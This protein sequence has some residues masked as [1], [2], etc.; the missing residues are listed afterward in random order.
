M[1]VDS[2]K[3]LA[4]DNKLYKE[5]VEKAELWYGRVIGLMQKASELPR[6]LPSSN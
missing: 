3:A 4:K 2:E 5:A 1:L 6:E